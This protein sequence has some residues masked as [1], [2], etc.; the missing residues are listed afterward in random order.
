MMCCSK[1][2]VQMLVHMACG[3]R[4]RTEGT[5]L[6]PP[7]S[8]CTYILCMYTYKVIHNIIMN[9]DLHV[10]VPALVIKAPVLGWYTFINHLPLN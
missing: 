9:R 10:H 2:S 6:D 4:V 7:W 5:G 3:I 8:T 1:Y